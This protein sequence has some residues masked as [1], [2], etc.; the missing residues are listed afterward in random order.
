LI[1]GLFVS[2][3]LTYALIEGW[4]IARP[5]G[6]L[7]VILMFVT[8][9]RAGWTFR[10]RGNFLA[11]DYGRDLL[12]ELPP[13]AVLFDPDDPTSFTVRALQ[14][15]EGRRMDVWPLNFF[16]TRW[17]YAE[18]R[19]R[20]DLL[21]PEAITNAQELEHAL[22]TYSAA[23]RPFYGELPQKLEGHLYASNGLVY[24]AGRADSSAS[25][26]IAENN[27]AR[28]M[29]HDAQQATDYPDFFARH[30]IS[31]YAAAHCNLGLEYAKAGQSD[32][33]VFHYRYALTL[34]PQLAVA[35]N[36]WG[37]IAFERRDFKRAIAL[38]DAGLEVE[39][40]NL[41]LQ[42]NKHLA[43][44]SSENTVRK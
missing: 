9:P 23:R 43:I 33:A 7:L 24:A 30:L 1:P 36:N 15:T 4:K 11:Y 34:D 35:Y 17:G 18:L 16:R 38:Y 25:R 28:L 8:L 31:Y 44:L 40:G 26:Q 10:E 21:P 39:P 6:V 42:S 13:Q 14:V 27:L 29:R 19:R 12:R 20:T 37:N 22:W 32:R 3:G 41:G 5:L 2:V